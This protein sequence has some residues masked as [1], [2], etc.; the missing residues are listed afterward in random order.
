MLRKDEVEDIF[1][2]MMLEHNKDHDFWCLPWHFGCSAQF[3]VEVFTEPNAEGGPKWETQ[4]GI[5]EEYPRQVQF[6]VEPGLRAIQN[7]ICNLIEEHDK[8]RNR[9]KV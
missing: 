6:H 9:A 1:R 4:I 5:I 2:A 8:K 3:K 7:L